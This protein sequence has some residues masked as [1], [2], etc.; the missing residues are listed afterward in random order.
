MKVKLLCCLSLA[1]ILIGLF[2]SPARAVPGVL[3]HVTLASSVVYLLRG[4]GFRFWAAAY[5]SDNAPISGLIFTWSVVN[6]GVSFVGSGSSDPYAYADF[7]A[8]TTLGRFWGT[9]KV[10]VIQG[11]ETR[12]ASA[13]VTVLEY[14]PYV[15]VA[16]N[17]KCQ[18]IDSPG[19]DNCVDYSWSGVN[20]NL[21]PPY[22]LYWWTYTPAGIKTDIET[23]T[24]NW[25]V[26]IP[27]LPFAEATAPYLA[28]LTFDYAPNPCGD[29][30]VLG[31]HK[32]NSATTIYG[33]DYAAS[34]WNLALIAINMNEVTSA[35][36]KA[37]AVVAHELGHHY[38]LD[39]RYTRD[40]LGWNVVCNGYEGTLMNTIDPGNPNYPGCPLRDG[41]TELDK[42]RVD[43]F[44]RGGTP[45]PDIEL[46][47]DLPILADAVG[48]VAT[49]R[50]QDMAWAEK[51]HLI[52]FYYLDP[53]WGWV[54][55]PALPQVNIP[56]FAGSH[57]YT[58]PRTMGWELDISQYPAGDVPSGTYRA[59]SWAYYAAA[60][61]YYGTE[62]GYGNDKCSD[63]VALTR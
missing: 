40:I 5:G 11:P 27:Y 19:T 21:P 13:T 56:Y 14:P 59:C 60:G 41:P 18:L 43:M 25:Q 48:P 52:V 57:L 39:E 7:T 1:G 44:W 46:R 49:Y 20:P 12:S 58:E 10:V 23:V 50:W 47:G 61:S 45:L 34:Y 51:S 53:Q 32:F 15:Y 9:V 35:G 6:G 42:Q 54:I 29:P 30:S 3:D 8:G 17:G 31:C 36:P 55:L 22:K 62:N 28:K 33:G 4:E 2:P 63:S 24:G 26:A 37:R 38:G 16:E